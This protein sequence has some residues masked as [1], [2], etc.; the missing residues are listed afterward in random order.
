[1]AVYNQ[2]AEVLLVSYEYMNGTF[3]FSGVTL[4]HQGSLAQNRA[5]ALKSQ[6]NE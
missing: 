4:G 5:G 2:A 1:M 3:K 6:D